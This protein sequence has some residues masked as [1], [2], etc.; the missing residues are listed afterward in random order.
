MGVVPYGTEPKV[1]LGRAKQT[2]RT[3]VAG[4]ILAAGRSSRMGRTKQL[5]PFRRKTVLDAVLNSVRASR[6]KP[7]V[8]VL[9][10]A[11]ERIRRTVE[12][13][14]VLVTVNG[15]YNQ[16]QSTSLKAGLAAIPDDVDAVMFIL[17][18]QPLISTQIIDRLVIEH[19]TRR[20]PLVIPVVE[21]KRGNPVIVGRA[22]FPAIRT[23]TG[24]TGAR[25][26]FD[27]F[28]DQIKTVAI[29]DPAIHFDI[30]HWE[31]YQRLKQIDRFR[32]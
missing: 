21:D 11:A 4:I 7:V 27:R 5:L 28:A 8:L 32:V 2:T 20:A 14:Q 22:L 26:L 18:D 12:L 24:D 30:D 16:G 25:M 6:L 9:G 19:E 15:D 17:G 29:H 3:T 1:T 10:H 31:D 23:L 13:G